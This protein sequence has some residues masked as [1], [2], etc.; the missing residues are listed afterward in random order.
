[1]EGRRWRISVTEARRGRDSLGRAA[2]APRRT[3]AGARR[4]PPYA[5]NVA[6]LK[7]IS[8]QDEV[9]FHM[10]G[11]E[12]V[13][14][15]VRLARYHTRRT[16]LVCFCGAYIG[17]WGTCSQEWAIPSVPR[18]VHVGR[19]VCSYVARLGHSARHRLRARQSVQGL[20]PN[21]A[22]PADASLVDRG[23]RAG[24]DKTACGELCEKIV[25]CS[26]RFPP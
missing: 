20:H 8:G 1:M 26:L 15:A 13:M 25:T 17:W 9:S 2:S 19:Y 10:S 24:F 5:D 12:A 7:H 6:R 21:M 3:W 4:L 14:Q 18:D 11:T 16:H 23:R 22:P